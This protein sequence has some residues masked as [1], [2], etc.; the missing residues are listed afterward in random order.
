MNESIQLL[1]LF[2][3]SG[4]NDV[5]DTLQRTKEKF[6]CSGA[7]I[8]KPICKTAEQCLNKL[9]EILDTAGN[10]QNLLARENNLERSIK[11]LISKYDNNINDI[12]L[13]N[14]TIAILDSIDKYL[15]SLPG[16]LKASVSIYKQA[17]N[18][19]TRISIQYGKS[20]NKNFLN[21]RN[22]LGKHLLTITKR[23]ISINCNNL[24]NPVKELNTVTGQL[25]GHIGNINNMNDALTSLAQILAILEKILAFAVIFI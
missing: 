21:D 23:N 19:D 9:N 20:K 12:V 18:L 24:E 3:G 14:E 22:T 13:H 15:M 6:S 17:D 5:R 16:E 2:K 10:E 7:N 4:S 25:K 11:D 8:G 1:I